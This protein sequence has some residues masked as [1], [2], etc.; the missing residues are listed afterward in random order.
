MNVLSAC[1]NAHWVQCLLPV[2]ARKGSRIP[3]TFSYKWLLVITRVLGIELA[4]LLTIDPSSFQSLRE[5]AKSKVQF[6]ELE[7]E[8]AW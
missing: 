4:R 3:L 1:M 6:H 5:V 7:K 8:S 2:K